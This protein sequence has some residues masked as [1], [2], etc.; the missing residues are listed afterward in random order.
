MIVTH[1]RHCRETM[2]HLGAHSRNAFRGLF[3]IRNPMIEVLGDDDINGSLLKDQ[4][5]IIQ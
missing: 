5:D 2:T 3:V 1:T 4:R